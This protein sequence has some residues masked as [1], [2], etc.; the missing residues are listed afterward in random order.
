MTVCFFSLYQYK[1]SNDS[2][3]DIVCES[4]QTELPPPALPSS[5][6]FLEA[7]KQAWQYTG[8]SFEG[9]KGMR[10]TPPH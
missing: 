6:F 1:V 4:R 8:R 7:S 3:Y 10:A 2:V 9:W 5:Q